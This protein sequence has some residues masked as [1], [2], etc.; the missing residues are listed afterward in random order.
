MEP[1]DLDGRLVGPGQPPYVIA[2]MSGNHN[3][4]LDRALAIVD[5]AK[6]AG[7]DALKIQTYTADTMTIESSSGEFFINDPDNI[8]SGTSMHQLYQKAYTPW[9][10]HPVI[11]DHCK[12][13]G[14]T[15]FSTPFDE[16]A[17]DFLETLAIPCYKISS[18]E[19]NHLPLLRK[20]ACTG[21]PIIMSTGMATYEELREAV[22]VIR[23]GNC[24]A[25][26][27]LK[28]VS[29]YPARAS[30]SNLVTIPALQR[31]FE[32]YVGLSDHTHGTAVAV[33]SVA[34]GATVIE[35]HFTLRRADGGVDAAFSLEPHEL[36]SLVKDSALAWSSLGKVVYGP[37]SGLEEKTSL[38][39]RSIYVVKD[40]A[41]G[42]L[43]T[44]DNLK[45]IRPGL[46]LAPK[47]IDQIIG[48]KAKKK[49]G[50]GTAL[51]WE[52]VE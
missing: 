2:E 4:S 16:T 13:V 15:C 50:R 35:K 36:A 51:G 9:D 39:R 3:Q 23:A 40:V 8:W 18:F 49:V 1:F 33:A 29:A 22:S 7:A 32:T 24:P 38:Y 27:L 37:S 43:F 19:N 52:F 44:H 25:L 10:W 42:E 5:A 34:L 12:K 14:I 26:V 17:V 30:D 41:E 20:V 31:E 28:C 6:E 11:F 47:F 46:G 48:K 21:K 45:I